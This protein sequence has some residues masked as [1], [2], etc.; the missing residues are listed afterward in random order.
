VDLDE[1]ANSLTVSVAPNDRTATL[2]FVRAMDDLSA[3]HRQILLLVG[4]EG[5]SYREIADE[6]AIPI[7]TV[8]SRLARA[9][10]QLRNRLEPRESTLG[11]MTAQP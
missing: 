2:D 11:S 6:L 5:L 4:M 7:G 8:M 1:M 10:D 3:D 9:R